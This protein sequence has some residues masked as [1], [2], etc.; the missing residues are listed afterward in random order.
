MT[1]IA[2]LAV[3]KS[4][5]SS[6]SVI[7]AYKQLEQALVDGNTSSIPNLEILEDTFFPKQTPEPLCAVVMYTL[8]DTLSGN[9]SS[10]NHSFLWTAS[11][12]PYTTGVLLLS[13]SQ[14]GIT[15]KGFEWER[16][17]LFRNETYLVL[18]LSS[19]N[20]SSDILVTALGDLT[21]QVCK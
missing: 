4:Y 13:Y 20:H 12:L 17:C 8:E 7:N 19:F 16:S 2:L 14:S 3:A 18:R 11:Y 21:S 9:L 6:I 1:L 10:V 5:G 15:L